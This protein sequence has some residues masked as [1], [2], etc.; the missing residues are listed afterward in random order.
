MNK[1][2]FEIC[3]LPARVEAG[4]GAEERKTK[5]RNEQS[6]RTETAQFYHGA[7]GDISTRATLYIT[8][9]GAAVVRRVSTRG[10]QHFMLELMTLVFD[11]FNYYLLSG[12][13]MGLFKSNRST[14]RPPSVGHPSHLWTIS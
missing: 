14:S 12:S 6:V 2:G 5:D 13:A 4:W 3:R 1:F 11:L 10:M 7:D 9:H 8:G